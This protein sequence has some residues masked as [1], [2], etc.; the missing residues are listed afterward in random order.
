M[1][2]EDGAAGLE[3]FHA[4]LPDLVLTDWTRADLRRLELAQDPQ[5]GANANPTWPI[6][7]RNAIPR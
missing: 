4:L 5:P 2:A 7:M 1:K 6:I 3:A